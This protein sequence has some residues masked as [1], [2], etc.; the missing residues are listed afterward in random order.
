MNS[1][2]K[3]DLVVDWASHDAARYACTNWHYSKVLPTGKLVKVGAWENGKFIGVVIFS[4]GAAMNIGRPYGLDQTEI[5]E[6]TRI[7]LTNHESFVS[8][9]MAAA[10]KFLKQKVPGMRLIVS[11]AD[12]MQGH[13]GGIYQATNWIYEGTSKMRWIRFKGKLTHPKSLYAKYNTQ[14]VEWLHKHVDP[15]A[16]WVEVPAKHKYLMPLDKK[17]R[18]QI[19]HLAKPYPKRRENES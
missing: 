5:C 10:F 2:H 13:H 11:Y 8:E 7:A 18:R 6:L 12:P 1:N 3:P 4:R 19:K 17:M 16:A 15:T 14:S 9:I